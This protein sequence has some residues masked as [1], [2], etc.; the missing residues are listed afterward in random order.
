M[1]VM[2]IRF[3]SAKF[4]TDFKFI[5]IPWRNIMSNV[6]LPLKISFSVFV[7]SLVVAA[8]TFNI[9]SKK[10]F[11]ISVIIALVS[12]IVMVVLNKKQLNN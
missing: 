8:I 12:A 6:G 5:R 1:D 10:I 9:E 11:F 3:I 4:L 2:I 7:V